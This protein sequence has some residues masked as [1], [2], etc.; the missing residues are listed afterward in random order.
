MRILSLDQGTTSTRLLAAG[1]AGLQVLGQLRHKTTYPQQ[2]WVEQDATEILSNCLK[3][4]AD[5]GPADAIGLANQGES[6]LAWDA[7]TGEPLSPI[8]VW[9][10]RRTLADLSAMEGQGLASE[11]KAR[12]GL[13]LDPY[14]S[15]AKLGW[16]LRE[17]P[18]VAKAHRLGRLR[19]GTSDAFLLDQ[20]TGTFAT[21]V[22]TAS[23]SGLMNLES[24]TWDASLCQ[25]FGV[26]IRCLPEIRGNLTGFGQVGGIPIT[27]SIVDQQAALYGHGCRLR[28]DTK[29]TFGTGAFALAVS[30]T[31]VPDLTNLR[32]LLPTVAWDLGHGP[33]YALDG[34]VQDAGSAVD[35]ALRAGIATGLEDF[36]NFTAAPAIERG[37][38]FL[39][40][41][42]GLGAPHWDRTAAPTLIGLTPEM[43]RR[44]MC[45]ALLEGIAFQS[46]ALVT[47]LGQ[48]LP[49]SGPISIDGGLSENRYFVSFLSQLCQREIAV[50]ASPERT[51]LGAALLA[52]R[53]LGQ[54]LP[55]DL[56]KPVIVM[57]GPTMVSWDARFAEGIARS[58]NWRN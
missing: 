53:A 44:D 15:A 51:A 56:A 40:A 4:L 26:P 47:E 18:A 2:A 50:S 7:L 46:A 43:T 13:P 21:D 25:M 32:G 24:C 9:Q 42:S 48:L 38:F 16:L 14:F 11:V 23:R 10:D 45:Q 5:V 29:I 1:E 54:T 28:G 57:P 19:L 58:H 6:C 33:V 37:L 17:R 41:F 20:M 31:A 39:P 8:I 36:D 49:F 27:A 22:A 12:S 35:W 30:G 55:D 52:A 3:L 34:G